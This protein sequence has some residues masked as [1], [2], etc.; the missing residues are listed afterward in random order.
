MMEPNGQWICGQ[1]APLPLGYSPSPQCVV[2]GRGGHT[3]GRSRLRTIAAQFLEQYSEAN[4]KVEKSAIVSKIV[5]MTEEG[6]P[7]GA[8]IKN[9]GGRWW[10]VGALKAREKVGYV[11]RDLLHDKYRSSTQSKAAARRRLRAQDKKMRT[12]SCSSVASSSSS[13]CSSIPDG[14]SLSM[15]ANEGVNHG[16]MK[17]PNLPT[18]SHETTASGLD[19]SATFGGSKRNSTVSHTRLFGQNDD[20]FEPTSFSPD[21]NTSSIEDFPSP[22]YNMTNVESL[23]AMTNP[24]LMD[25]LDIVEMKGNPSEVPVGEELSSVFD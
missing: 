13:S 14:L 1:E 20:A 3:T 5:H 11:L 16:M 12:S 25:D 21:V 17:K 10:Q 8:F 24:Q 2:I 6:C 19:C 7:Y 18:T 9:A 4:T 22:Y 23:G 15:K